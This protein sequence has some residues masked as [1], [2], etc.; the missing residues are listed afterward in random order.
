MLL[1][2]SCRPFSNRGC[3]V[4]LQS[5][6]LVKLLGVLFAAGVMVLSGVGCPP[7]DGCQGC[8]AAMCE[9]A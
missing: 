7:H 6:L 5:G 3:W 4:K 8:D 1:R 9:A 2:F